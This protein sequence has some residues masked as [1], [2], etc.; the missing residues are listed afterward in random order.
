MGLP[1]FQANYTFSESLD[2]TSV[3]MWG[4]PGGASGA[5]A[6]AYPQDPRDPSADKGR[7]NFDVTHMASVSLVQA[8]PLERW[9]CSPIAWPPFPHRLADLECLPTVTSGIPFTIYSGSEETAAGTN[10]TGPTRSNQPPHAL[11]HSKCPGGLFRE[12]RGQRSFFYIPIGIEGGTGPNRGRFV[13]G[14]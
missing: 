10:N 8:L 3:A 2:D 1:G 7:S 12:R 5:A 14:P 6:Q 11:D 9:R 13:L 4:I